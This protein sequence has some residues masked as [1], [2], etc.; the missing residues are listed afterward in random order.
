MKAQPPSRVSALEPGED[1]AVGEPGAS[2]IVGDLHQIRLEFV[3]MS[4]RTA[5]RAG[6]AAGTAGATTST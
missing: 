2:A 5:G 4:D 6:S 3:E 1:V